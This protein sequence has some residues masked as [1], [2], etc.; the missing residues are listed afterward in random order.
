MRSVA[1]AGDRLTWDRLHPRRAREARLAVWEGT[2][3]SSENEDVQKTL[4]AASRLTPQQ[5]AADEATSSETPR[6]AIRSPK[7]VS[8]AKRSPLSAPALRAQPTYK[9]L[10]K[11]AEDS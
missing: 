7:E 9:P 6:E 5:L 1:A 2:G 8:P 11:E 3:D 4:P 10:T